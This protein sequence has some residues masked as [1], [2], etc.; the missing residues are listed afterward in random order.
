MSLKDELLKMSQYIRTQIGA[1]ILAIMDKAMADFKAQKLASKGA[2]VGDAFPSAVLFNAHGKEVALEELL[3]EGPL[4]VTFYR[5]GW[6][7]Y[8]N[9]ELKS[10]QA[11]LSEIKANGGQLVAITPEPSAN[12]LAT[13]Q[14]NELS[15]D[16]LTDEENKLAKELGILMFLTEELQ[17]LYGGAHLDWKAYTINEKI[18][19]PIPATFVV[20]QDGIIIYRFIDEDYTKRAEPEEVLGVL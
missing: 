14:Q 2:N 3:M 15:F 16:I 7:P 6:C 9:L 5:G 18:A 13:S 20:G 17:N 1:E 4:V 8:C 11:V 12:T 19:L 10:Y